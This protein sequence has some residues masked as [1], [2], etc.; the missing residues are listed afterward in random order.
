MDKLDEA[1]E[2]FER[3]IQFASPLGLFSEEVDANT[4]AL[5]GNYPQAYTH[6]G[7]VIAAHHL[8]QATERAEEA[9]RERQAQQSSSA[10]DPAS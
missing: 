6:I 5:L 1:R 7:L 8:W 9:E 2:R 3:L 10:G 4:G